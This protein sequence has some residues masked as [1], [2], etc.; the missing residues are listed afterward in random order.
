V[1]G[2]DLDRIVIA[3][4][5][6]ID[7][8]TGEARPWTLPADVDLLGQLVREHK[9]DLVVIDPLG[10]FVSKGVDTHR[11]SSVRAMLF[12]LAQ[13]A[14]KE[15]CAVLGIRHLR[16]GGAADARDAGSGSVAFTAAARIEWLAGRDPQ[17]PARC[18]LAVSKTN[19]AKVPTSLVYRLVEAAEWDTV[20]T[21]WD[22]TSTLTANQ[23]VSEQVNDG[24]QSELDEASDFLRE[25]LADGP[26]PSLVIEELAEQAGIA[27][28]TL[29]RA[30]KRLGVKVTKTK[31]GPWMCELRVQGGQLKDEG[32]GAAE[33]PYLGPLG[34]LGHLPSSTT[35]DNGGFSRLGDKG[36]QGG[37]GDVVGPNGHLANLEDEWPP[38]DA[39]GVQ[40]LVGSH[41]V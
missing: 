16:K 26:R 18:I 6:V 3:D 39:D 7:E 37:Q 23:L 32:G 9:V 35:Y 30:K 4:G 28:R 1:A 15:R 40:S 27:D 13:M 19:L 24:D 10:A 11:D 38:P 17:D 2:A 20:R 36:G 12:P 21:A 14:R 8:V 29:R 22:G 34:P 25:A 5:T 33:H 41:R 31:A